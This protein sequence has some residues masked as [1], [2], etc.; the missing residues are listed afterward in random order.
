MV[1]AK[2]S[3]VTQYEDSLCWSQ[4]IVLTSLKVSRQNTSE[5]PFALWQYGGLNDWVIGCGLP[6]LLFRVRQK[7]SISADVYSLPESERRCRTVIPSEE[8]FSTY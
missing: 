6:S 3:A 8:H 5:V 7:V 4:R 2:S 1:L